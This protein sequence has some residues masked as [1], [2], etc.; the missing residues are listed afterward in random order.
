MWSY[1]L[2]FQ[3]WVRWVRNRTR[4]KSDEPGDLKRNSCTFATKVRE[5]HYFGN[6]IDFIFNIF[7]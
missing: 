3:K 6:N 7:T 5:S 2:T 4:G 1:L